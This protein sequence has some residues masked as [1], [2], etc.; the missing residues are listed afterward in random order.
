MPRGRIRRPC[1]WRLED[2]E[3]RRLRD[4]VDRGR[5][6]EANRAA[7][8][9]QRFFIATFAMEDAD[10]AASPTTCCESCI[11]HGWSCRWL[12]PDLRT[13]TSRAK[14][15]LCKLTNQLCNPDKD[16][17]KDLEHPPASP[18]TPRPSF[19][20]EVPHR[21]RRFRR[22][23][24]CPSTRRAVNQLPLP[25]YSTGSVA[26]GLP[27]NVPTTSPAADDQAS[28]D[29]LSTLGPMRSSATSRHIDRTAASASSP[30]PSRSF[31]PSDFDPWHRFRTAGCGPSDRRGTSPLSSVPSGFNNR[32]TPEA[33]PHLRQGTSPLS[34][35]PADFHDGFTAQS[36][37]FDLPH[38]GVSA[39]AR[40]PRATTH[41]AADATMSVVFNDDES[42]RFDTADDRFGVAGQGMSSQMAA[43]HQIV[44][45][46][47]G[48]AEE[49]RRRH[50][51]SIRQLQ[52]ADTDRNAETERLIAQITRLQTQVDDL[53]DRLQ[54]VDMSA[55][56]S[57]QTSSIPAS[58]S[59]PSPETSGAEDAADEILD[60][61]HVVSSS[62]TT[63]TSSEGLDIMDKVLDIDR[64]LTGATS[65]IALLR[66]QDP[67]LSKR[68]GLTEL[69]V[70]ALCK[71][72]DGE[73]HLPPGNQQNWIET[74][75]ELALQ[76]AQEA[77][78]S[79]R[80]SGQIMYQSDHEQLMSAY[81]RGLQTSLSLP[82]IEAGEEGTHRSAMVPHGQT[83]HERFRVELEQAIVDGVVVS[84][85]DLNQHIENYLEV[86]LQ[87]VSP[88]PVEEVPM[89]ATVPDFQS[90]SSTTQLDLQSVQD[91][92]TQQVQEQT[93]VRLHTLESE[94]RKEISTLSRTLTEHDDSLHAAHQNTLDVTEQVE[95]LQHVSRQNTLDITEQV[96]SFQD[97]QHQHQ[98]QFLRQESERPSMAAPSPGVSSIDVAN[99]VP[100]RKRTASPAVARR[101]DREASVISVGTVMHYIVAPLDSA[102]KDLMAAPAAVFKRPRR[103]ASS[104][105][106]R[107]R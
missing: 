35:V 75:N 13:G 6:I 54:R 66:N 63:M 73:F 51:E 22:S 101:E 103:M 27:S 91:Y 4:V 25:H 3:R 107:V 18:A 50:A 56:A 52:Q 34:S 55:R 80:G 83:I 86:R 42:L 30:V 57:L 17:Y 68:L 94:L 1:F 98:Q 23:I 93:E 47:Q 21:R 61:V 87:N 67:K 15:A 85:A 28:E 60:D 64:R 76:K 58:R 9:L 26:L 97:L 29:E 106:I 69:Q 89:T 40:S 82:L 20:D 44:I 37:G 5:P 2:T 31:R 79:S 14:C 72:K 62:S 11:N 59:G 71:W 32:S 105:A 70:A 96:E 92:V 65:D 7:R 90:T 46:V 48:S 45:A 8:K 78:E 41:E 10:W 74:I 84:L 104:G 77:I 81:C 33:W 100:G 102:I 36:W 16:P 43:L 53:S 24:L 49:D 88:P 95:T 39:H 19:P 12:H 38:A 99:P